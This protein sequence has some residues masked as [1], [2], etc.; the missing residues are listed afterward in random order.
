MQG[1]YI[2]NTM[3]FD[4][5]LELYNTTFSSPWVELLPGELYRS[6]FVSS[7]KRPYTIDFDVS[8]HLTDLLST[9]EIRQLSSDLLSKIKNLKPFTLSFGDKNDFLNSHDITG[10]GGAASVFGSVISATKQFIE[11]RSQVYRR[12]KRNTIF[13]KDLDAKSLNPLIKKGDLVESDCP[14]VNLLILSAKEASRRK[15]YDRMT[16]LLAKQLNWD[17]GIIDAKED[18]YYLFVRK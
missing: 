1:L 5:I 11:G 10:A 17:L 9:K 8:E 7:A 15:L 12:V 14:T 13:P 3:K 6:E 16:P 18:R 4:I 2:N